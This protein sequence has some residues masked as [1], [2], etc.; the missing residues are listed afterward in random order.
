MKVPDKKNR[1]CVDYRSV[2][3][4]TIRDSFPI[5]LLGDLLTRVSGCRYFSKLD[6]KSAFNFIRIKEGDEWKTAFRTPWGLF[7]CLVMPFGLANGPACFQ[8][9]VQSILSEYLG[10]SC[11]VYIDDILI[12]SKTREDH[13]LHVADRKSVV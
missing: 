11:F 8:R 3:S 7:E 4:M 1:P 10:I 2:N 9:F 12:F 13:Q 5:P 6:L